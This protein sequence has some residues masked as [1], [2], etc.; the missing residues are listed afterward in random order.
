MAVLALLARPGILHARPVAMTY[1]IY[2]PLNGLAGRCARAVRVTPI[3][4]DRGS[5]VQ[6]TN[7]ELWFADI[8]GKSAPDRS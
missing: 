6:G 8:Q 7:R 3:R 2:Q 4:V 5:P 1:E